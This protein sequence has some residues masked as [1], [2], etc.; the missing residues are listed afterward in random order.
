MRFMMCACRMNDEGECARRYGRF[1]SR[2]TD[3]T[4]PGSLPISEKLAPE[5]FYG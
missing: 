4:L 3:G 1:A 2:K 5:I